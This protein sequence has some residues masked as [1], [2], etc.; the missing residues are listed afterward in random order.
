MPFKSLI[1]F[2]LNIVR[3]SLQNE[4]DRFFGL[5]DSSE[6]PFRHVTKSAFSQARRYLKHTA[7]VELGQR[8]VQFFYKH[9]RTN[10]WLGQR[11]IAMDG[12]TCRIPE[13]GYTGQE[14]EN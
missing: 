5:I 1:L 6:I 7:F 4:L 12:S 13:W 14:N 8:A 3:S 2:L 11:L 10:L 9:A